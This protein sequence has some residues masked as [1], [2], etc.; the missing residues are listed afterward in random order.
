MVQLDSNDSNGVGVGLGHKQAHKEG[1]FEL[2]HILIIFL[3]KNPY[4]G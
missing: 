2:K 4:C 1:E 3:Q